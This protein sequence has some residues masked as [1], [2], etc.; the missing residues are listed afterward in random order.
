MG[1]RTVGHSRMLSRQIHKNESPP[2]ATGGLHI[3][4]KGNTLNTNI[5]QDQRSPFDAIMRT[6]DY[7]NEYWSAR[8]LAPLMGYSAWQNFETPLN[9]AMTA[10]SNQ[11]HEVGIN[12]MRSH[13]VAV[14]GKRPQAD[15]N[16]TRFACYLVAMNG[17]PNKTEVAEAQMYFAIQTRV[18]ET[19]PQQAPMQL[20]RSDLARMVLESEGELNAAKAE[21]QAAAPKVEYVDTFVADQD[22]MT[23]RSLA[24][25][26]HVGE[27]DLRNG[28]I[29]AN[30]IYPKVLTRWSEKRQEK[31]SVT[32]YSARSHKADYFHIVMHHD[33]PR[34]GGEIMHTL[35]ITPPGA[36]AIT[37]W[38]RRIEDEYGSLHAA[39]PALRH[40]HD[41]RKVT[42]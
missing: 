18:A 10:A 37:R 30:W 27:Q 41:S 24:A 38:L 8:D 40:K 35:K 42:K 2:G 20:S 11:G 29:Y 26:L 17:D 22:K 15:F 32:R 23:F 1:Y 19:Q 33:V 36:Q 5:L 4:S 12:F 21:L 31:V 16:L 39:L 6:D 25:V 7:G 9:R 3:P 14:P 34:F 13:K 28:L